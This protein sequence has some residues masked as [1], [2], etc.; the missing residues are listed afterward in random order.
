MILQANGDS[1]VEMEIRGPR[2]FWHA[3]NPSWEVTESVFKLYF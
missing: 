2:K 3:C 1:G